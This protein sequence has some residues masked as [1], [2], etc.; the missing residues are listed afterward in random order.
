MKHIDLD[1]AEEED[2]L[3]SVNMCLGEQEAMNISWAAS[4]AS[5]V[6]S[7]KRKSCVTSLLPLFSEDSKSP[8]MIKHGIDIICRA[9]KLLNP[10]Q[11]PVITMDEPLFCIAKQLQWLLPQKYGEKNLVLLLGGL[12]EEKALWSM[13]GAL[14]KN[15]G[16]VKILS[17][18]CVFT[19]GRA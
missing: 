8:T 16:W 6:R 10:S 17:K 3:K 12:H 18:S 14:L 4:H 1:L 13:L 9:V 2:W 19:A 15:S 5:K 7:E 11:T